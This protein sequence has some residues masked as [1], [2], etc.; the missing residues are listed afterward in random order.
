V[1]SGHTEAGTDLATLAGLPPVG[2]LAELVNDD[3][4]VQRLPELMAFSREHNL[5]IITIADLIAYRQQR[6]QLVQRSYEFAVSTAIGKAQAYGYKTKFE[7][8]EHI[9]LVFGDIQA[10]ESVPVRIHREKLVEDIFGAQSEEHPNNLLNAAMKRIEALGGGVL[11]YLRTG[12]VGVPLE[13]F[14]SQSREDQRRSQWLEVGVGAQI[15]RDL[16]LSKIR[17]IAGRNVDYVGVEGFGLTLV[18]TEML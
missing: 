12:F 6:E 14:E 17:L 7:E 11:I 1:R 3:G 8:A 15:L 4:T 13:D 9:A 5:K 10:M 16:G 2:L 18:D